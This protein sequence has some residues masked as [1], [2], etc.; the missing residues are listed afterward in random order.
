MRLYLV[1]ELGQLAPAGAAGAVGHELGHLGRLELVVGRAV[2]ELA[3]AVDGRA[4]EPSGER[5]VAKLP[6]AYRRARQ[7]GRYEEARSFRTTRRWTIPRTQTATPNTT[8]PTA[9]APPTSVV[10]FPNPNPSPQH[11]PTPRRSALR[12]PRRSVTDGLPAEPF[13]KRRVGLLKDLGELGDR[14]RP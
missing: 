13:N 10:W 3:V 5:A 9:G 7:F 2:R 4:T 12:R 11:P 1:G 6:R 14:N 8:S